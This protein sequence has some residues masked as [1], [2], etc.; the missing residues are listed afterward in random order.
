MAVSKVVYPNLSGA[1]RI[2]IFSALAIGM[3]FPLLA[4][5]NIETFSLGLFLA[6][7]FLGL[8]EGLAVA[9]VAGF[10]FILFNPNGPQTILL[11]GLAQEA[12]FIL[13]AFF[14]SLLRK[15]LL[16]PHL[17]KL[18]A[19]IIMAGSGLILTLIYDLATN[20]VF[21]VLFGPF[22]PALI[23][24]LSFSLIHILSNIVIFGFSALIIR[25]VWQRVEYIMPR[26]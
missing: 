9:I 15:I 1:A 3:N 10:I 5:P 11:V 12:G 8:S 18:I 4:I 19:I 22:W 26:L 6:G 17:D 14:G 16:A 21:A 23:G 7:L 13:F 2:G 20:L 25:K 24:G